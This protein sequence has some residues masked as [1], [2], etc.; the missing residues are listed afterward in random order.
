M[1]DDEPVWEGTIDNGTWVARV[2]QLETNAYRGTLTVTKVSDPGVVL[3]DEEVGL[4]YAAQFG[5][6][7]DDVN[8]WTTMTIEVI[9][10]YYAQN[11]EEDPTKEKPDE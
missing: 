5:P 2:T 10:H 4:S 11:P 6:D 8:M 9:D 3:L 7:V 1:A